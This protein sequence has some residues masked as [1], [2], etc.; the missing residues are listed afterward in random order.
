MKICSVK[1]RGL[2]MNCA[3]SSSIMIKTRQ[4]TPDNACHRKRNKL[5]H[6]QHTSLVNW[7]NEDHFASDNKMIYI[8]F[9]HSRTSLLSVI[10]VGSAVAERSFS[11]TRQFENWLPNSMLTD[12]LGN[13]PIAAA[14]GHTILILKT[15]ICSAYKSIHPCRMMTSSVFFDS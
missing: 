12:L 5:C 11:C 15:D 9:E 4:M 2:I 14:R 1:K 13:L 8:L 6:H 10:P 7:L 3:C